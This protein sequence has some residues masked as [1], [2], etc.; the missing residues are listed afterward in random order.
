ML[1]T[2]LATYNQFHQV[3]IHGTFGSCEEDKKRVLACMK[4]RSTSGEKRER[5]VVSEAINKVLV[6]YC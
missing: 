1:I 4:W 5:A 6:M 3:Y 2:L